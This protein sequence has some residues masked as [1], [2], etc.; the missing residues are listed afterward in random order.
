MLQGGELV[1]WWNLPNWGDLPTTGKI[2][3]SPPL[4]PHSTVLTQKCCADFAIF[5]QFLA[6]LAKLCLRHSP[7]QNPGLGPLQKNKLC[8]NQIKPRFCNF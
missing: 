4:C 7:L 2:G 1:G 3:L 6:I 5:K 8:L